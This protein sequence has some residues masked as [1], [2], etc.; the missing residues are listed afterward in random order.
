RLQQQI[1][2]SPI[3]FS[4]TS[5]MINQQ[6]PGAGLTGLAG[7]SLVAPPVSTLDAAR[8]QLLPLSVSSGSQF[9]MPTTTPVGFLP[10][11]QVQASQSLALTN[12]RPGAPFFNSN[13]LNMVPNSTGGEIGRSDMS[14]AYEVIDRCNADLSLLQQRY[15]TVLGHL[16]AVSAK[17]LESDARLNQLAAQ[18][19][20]ELKLSR[21]H[22][23]MKRSFEYHQLPEIQRMMRATQELVSRLSQLSN[24]AAA[25][26][27]TAVVVAPTI[28]TIPGMR[29]GGGGGEVGVGQEEKEAGS[30]SRNKWVPRF[31]EGWADQRPTSAAA[32]R[33]MAALSEF[34]ST[35]NDVNSKKR[36]S[37]FD[38]NADGSPVTGSQENSRKRVADSNG[39]NTASI[40]KASVIMSG[41]GKG[42][43]TGP[44]PGLDL[45]LDLEPDLDQRLCQWR[46]LLLEQKQVLWGQE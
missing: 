45:E 10:F 18:V 21:M 43:G 27:A 31:G 9:M 30:V 4:A 36:K 39:I 5:R 40:S 16:H 29:G 25:G 44:G 15:S 32:A 6:V 22:Q 7:P 19:E 24:S 23:D 8:S 12:D 28:K 14:L 17:A 3:L 37:G 1:E 41:T 2:E 34:T 26:S 35:S 33:A 38:T 20:L 42:A 46:L 11:Q 13:G